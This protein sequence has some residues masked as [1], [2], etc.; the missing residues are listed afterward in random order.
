MPKINV[1]L[2]DALA[3][4]VKDAG[5]PVSAVCQAA[6]SDAVERVGQ[7]RRVITFLRDE[8]TSAA[9]FGRLATGLQGKMTARLVTA[10]TVAGSPQDGEVRASVST[11]DLLRGLLDD[12][13][14]LAVRLL[15][16]Q[17]I[18]VDLLRELSVT[19]AADEAVAPTTEP[20]DTILARMTMPA[21]AACAAALEAVIE[22]GHNYVGCEHLLIGLAASEGQAANL[23]NEQ[24]VRV[25]TV[26][27][28]L[29]G[30]IAGVVHERRTSVTRDLDAFGD[31]A[32]RIEAI[33]RQ[34]AGKAS[35]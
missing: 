35:T 1:Y 4:A 3:S 6:L 5:V 11:L 2:P 16:A 7:T 13:E 27:Q 10:F 28:A 34:L 29:N 21:R 14:N 31:L 12:G 20:A 18:D 30:A 32:R 9:V 33:E 22:L 17:D 23:L 8:S 19:S 24:G 25:E 15:V 26:R